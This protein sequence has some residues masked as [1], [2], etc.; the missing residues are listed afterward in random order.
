MN[1]RNRIIMIVALASIICTTA[2]VVVSVSRIRSEGELAL[3]NKARAILSRLEAVR[4]FIA[5]QGG[6][7]RTIADV[8]TKFPD[9]RLTKEAKL[10][11]LK[12]VPIFASMK[13]GSDDAEK[14]NYRFRIFADNPRNPDNKPNSAEEDI[15]RRFN[16]DAGLKE[17][18]VKDDQTLAVYRPIRLSEAQ[19]CLSCHG[20]P[21]TSPWG[22]GKDVLGYEMENWKDNFQ[23]GVFGVISDLKEVREASFNASVNIITWAGLLTVFALALAYYLIRGPI[24]Q[25]SGVA[26]NLKHAGE[27][28]SAASLEISKSSQGLSASTTEAAA[29]IEETTAS[30]EEVSSMIRM[31]AGHAEEAKNLSHVC[32]EN[33]RTGQQQVEK[34]IVA[35]SDITTSSKKIEEI[36]NVIDDIAFQTNLLALN[37]AVEA[38]RAG[39]Q[40][41][42]FAVVADAVR[43]LAQRSALS[44]KEISDLIKESVTKIGQGSQI[45]ENSGQALKQI[46][47]SVEKVAT[48]N[49]EISNASQEQSK[50]VSDINK[51]I[52]ELD[53]V[54]QQNAAGAE[55]TAAAGEELSAQATNMHAYVGELI[56]VLEGVKTATTSANHMSGGG[57]GRGS[58]RATGGAHG[59]AHGGS[60]STSHGN[61]HGNDD[62]SSERAA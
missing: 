38:A 25:I 48:L 28:V 47:E 8:K 20:E 34:L 43:S 36:I 59:Y 31:N 6:L 52:N 10:D 49:S 7:N 51:A 23:H 33:A 17:W 12:Q 30:A 62:E 19:G 58:R 5:G 21:K 15:L 41:K 18:V 26:M 55:E 1:F 9:G 2:A 53:K 24:N 37:A 57:A 29:S 14:E 32:Q 44:A 22:N 60:H 11:V 39:E 61:S 35:M 45:A 3:T 54:T 16:A 13:V 4:E 27:Q 46:V 50:G 40:G 56:G 42:G